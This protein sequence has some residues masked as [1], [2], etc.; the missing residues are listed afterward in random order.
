MDYLQIRELYHYGVKGQK[1][2]VRRYQ[3]DDGT[4]TEE[5]K[6]RYGVNEFGQM[7]K[8]GKKLYKQ[9]VKEEAK[10]VRKGI[11]EFDKANKPTYGEDGWETTKRIAKGINFIE[12]NYSKASIE[13]YKQ[14]ETT[15]AWISSGA[16][17]ASIIGAG[18]AVYKLKN[19]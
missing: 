17:L 18:I 5:G 6:K 11:K 4:L 14:Q 1:W 3:N 15:K 12:K 9:D 19:Q 7:S 8:E 2:G 10:S 13:K 16:A